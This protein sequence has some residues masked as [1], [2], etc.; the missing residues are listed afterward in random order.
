MKKL[1]L[2]AAVIAAAVFGIFKVHSENNI[3]SDNMNALQIENVEILAEGEPTVFDCNRVCH[4][5]YDCHCDIAYYWDRNDF[6]RCEGY[7]PN[8]GYWPY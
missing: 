8:S 2:S 1:I 5:A 6:F 4:A 3:N 7:W